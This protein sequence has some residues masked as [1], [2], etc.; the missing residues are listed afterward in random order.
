MNKIKR[1]LSVVL[2][3][4]MM[5]SM[6][7][8]CQISFAFAATENGYTYVITAD[9]TAT[10][11]GYTGGAARIE[12]PEKLGGVNVAAIGDGAFMD[13]R[14]LST[15][16]LSKNVTAIGE[17]AFA[18]CAALTDVKVSDGLL[19]IGDGA[20]LNCASLKELKLGNKATEL[21][22]GMLSG[23]T[24]LS[25]LTVPA[26]NGTFATLFD[27]AAS[28]N[29]S[30]PAS[31]KT[32]TVTKDDTVDA[33]AFKGMSAVTKI[34]WQTAPVEVGA[35]AFEGCTALSELNLSTNK[36][37]T[38][39]A[40]AFKNCKALASFTLS[41]KVTGVEAS[42][43]E[44]CAALATIT[45]SDKLMMV[46]ENAFKGTAWLAA[47][48]NGP[49]LL[50]KVFITFKGNDKTVEV[51]ASATFIADAAFKGNTAV[52]EVVIHDGVDYIGKNILVDTAVEKVTVPFVGPAAD[53]IDSLVISYLFG[54]ENAV[55]NAMVMPS[56]LKEVVLTDCTMIPNQAFEGV[57]YITTVTIPAT[58]TSVNAAAFK[59]CA[60]LE[61][62]NYNA[63]NAVIAADAFEGSNV[64]EVNFGEGVKTIPTYLCTANSNLLS[65]IIPASVTKIDGRAFAGCYN[66]T[67]V[68]KYAEN[69]TSVAADAFDYCHKLN[70]VVLRD[71][72]KHIP[73]N[74]YSRYGGSAIEIMTIPEN[75]TSIAESAFSNCTALKTLYFDP[76]ACEIG[77]DAFTGCTSLNKIVLGKKV[78]TI[79][80][81]LYAGNVAITE[82]TIPETVERIDD[83]AFSGCTA[84]EK[85]TVGDNLLDIGSNVTNGSKW[86]D[87]QGDGPLYLGKV[88]VGYKGSLPEGN[89]ITLADGTLA[90]S[91]GAFM[92]NGTLVDVF[93][94]N[95]V[96]YIGVD[97]FK[98]TAASITCYFE[99]D[100]VIDYANQNGIICNILDCFHDNAYYV[101]VTEATA[102]S[103]GVWEK[104]CSD[105]G[106]IVATEEYAIGEE[107]NVWVQTK[108]PTCGAAGEAAKGTETKAIPAVSHKKSIWKETKAATCAADGE[109]CEFCADCGEKLSGVKVLPKYEHVA[110]GWTVIKQPRTY[111]EG[112][113]AVLCTGCGEILKSKKIEKL[114]EDD[115]M[116][117]LYGDLFSSEWYYPTVQFVLNNGLMNGVKEDT[118]D[119]NGTMTRAMFVTVIGRMA[120]VDVDH[121]VK[122]KFS[123]VKKNQY[124]TGYVAWAVENGIVNGV[125]NKTFAPNDP[126]TREQ[127]CTMIVR[128]ADYSN[129][130]L[131]AKKD[132]E[133]FR[134]ADTISKYAVNAVLTCQKAGLVKGRGQRYFAPK[135]KATRAEVAQILKNLALGFLAD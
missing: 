45:V 55:Q 92:G 71:T 87:L 10:I 126:I 102:E 79:P 35:S 105:C 123:D 67:T 73:A 118:F 24:A 93:V 21:G 6:L 131:T 130:E 30:F 88:Y 2:S 56:S 62:V 112:V 1:V 84:L 40:A 128:F 52:K 81:N 5:V 89:S 7:T 46:G 94:P 54:G 82:L 19:S 91:D 109:S 43:F 114:A 36:V 77:D 27:G 121:N 32:V 20:F 129:L 15:V 33:N 47:Q 78:T 31:L 113:N 44:G 124:Y 18:G 72:V 8:V 98:D 69:C 96:S 99:A 61:V 64:A 12:L 101:I 90:V 132:A 39:G 50:N 16:T 127:I 106:Q 26:I 119:P 23:C 22:I 53:S 95:T 116:G 25:E 57:A 85:I 42:A 59:N 107:A 49:V 103:A 115:T 37:E 125:T 66:I 111:C 86:Y 38:I 83:Y 133:I 117:V 80:S 58:A 122:T 51:P 4:L 17:S 63:V 104:H 13:N 60:S 97:A 34:D 11:T 110:G 29:A 48:A 28:A 41:S 70:E 120:G 108:A 100:Y 14:T 76:P 135:A 74:L 65:V 9:N 68:E 134:D 3:V 75:I